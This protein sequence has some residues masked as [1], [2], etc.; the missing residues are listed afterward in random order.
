MLLVDED[1]G[2]GRLAGSLQKVVL[3]LAAVRSFV[4]LFDIDLILYVGEVGSEEVLCPLAVW[5]V[6]LGEYDD[7][8][9][10]NGIF[11]GLLSRHACSRRG[12]CETGEERSNRP[13]I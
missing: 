9:A 2:D 10:G 13:V 12:G 7:L 4:E 11:D 8:V 3:D 6:R 1:V 5:A